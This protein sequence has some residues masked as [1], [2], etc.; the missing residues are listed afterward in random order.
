MT[1]KTRRKRLWKKKRIPLRL[2]RKKKNTNDEDEDK[3]KNVKYELLE[4]EFNTLK[5][6]YSQLQA[7]YEELMNF[8][9]QIENQKKDELIA[10]FYMLS[11]EDKKDVIDNKTNY[12]LDEIKAKLSVICFDKKINF[13]MDK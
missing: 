12:T 13:T 6:S 11:D 10:E 4:S 7:Q 9:N 2:L 5:E 8:K 1:R 3:K